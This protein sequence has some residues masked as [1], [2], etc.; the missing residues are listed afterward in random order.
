MGT[1]PQTVGIPISEEECLRQVQASHRRF[2]RKHVGKQVNVNHGPDNDAFVLQVLEPK[3]LK[4]GEWVNRQFRFTLNYGDDFIRPLLTI[5]GMGNL[6]YGAN[7]RH[8]ELFFVDPK[9][10]LFIIQGVYSCESRKGIV[11]I[12]RG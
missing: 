6:Q 12:Q 11:E 5:N 7:Q 10:G 3:I 2:F 1:E 4:N 8:V 9:E